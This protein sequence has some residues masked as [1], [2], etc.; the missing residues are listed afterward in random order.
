MLRF[1]I[2]TSGID[3]LIKSL[4]PDLKR[5]GETLDL[6]GGYAANMW[7]GAASGLMLPG[8]NRKVVWPAYA[9]S[10]K[11]NLRGELEVVVSGD[12]SMTQSATGAQSAWDMKPGLLAHAKTAKDGH[13]Y[14][15][16]PFTHK[17]SNLSDEA[18]AALINNVRN[19]ASEVGMRSKILSEGSVA[20]RAKGGYA[21]AGEA[22]PVSNYTWTTGHE[23][24]IRMGN[25]GPATFRVVSD[26]SNPASWWYPAR[27]ENPIL[28]AV[29]DAV[30]KDIE[31]W[32]V[33]AWWEAMGNANSTR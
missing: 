14:K 21:N 8:M 29:W 18:V 10:I 27:T 22:I 13:R 16:I 3:G 2:D 33:S 11:H 23:S 32:I 9:Q 31:E 20:Y 30:K 7:E 1:D 15:V 25:N 5:V 19:F 6:A 4:N 24:G 12:Q 28:E 17:F 26:R